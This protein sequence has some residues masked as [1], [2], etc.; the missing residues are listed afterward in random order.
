MS[1]QINRKKQQLRYLNRRVTLQK[2]CDYTVKSNIGMKDIAISSVIIGVIV[3]ILY[4]NQ[5]RCVC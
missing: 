5:V 3:G 4:I 2:V 1:I